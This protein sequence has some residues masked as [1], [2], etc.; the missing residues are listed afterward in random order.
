MIPRMLTEAT[1]GWSYRQG[2]AP[3]LWVNSGLPIQMKLKN[4]NLVLYSNWVA[5]PNT[6]L[7]NNFDVA[8]VYG[9]SR[10]MS[11]AVTELQSTNVR[12]RN[13]VQNIC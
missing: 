11:Q 2:A 3:L 12:T 5:N 6:L 10:G 1:R 13:E 7:C 8:R 9:V 4:K